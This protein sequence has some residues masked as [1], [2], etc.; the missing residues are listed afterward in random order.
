MTICRIQWCCWSTIMSHFVHCHSAESI[1]LKAFCWKHSA[2]RILLKAF[3]WKH[4]AE[5]ILLKA[6]YKMLSIMSFHWMS[7]C[8][9]LFYW[10]SFCWM[11]ICWMLFHWMSFCWSHSACWWKTLINIFLLKV[12]ALKVIQW[13]VVQL[14]VAAPFYL[15]AL[16]KRR[17]HLAQILTKDRK[18][19]ICC[20][21]SDEMI[22]G[23]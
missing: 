14:N 17:W 19:I 6:F 13:S 21:C 2:E 3:C 10:M 5:S 9:M 1:I 8:L 7:F 4:S 22:V 16:V 20:N 23:K 12:V 11:S 18:L 15:F